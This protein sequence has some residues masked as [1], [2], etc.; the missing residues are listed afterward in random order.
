MLKYLFETVMRM[1]SELIGKFIKELREEKKLTQLMLAE[2]IPVTRE[3]VSKWERGKNNPD[4]ETLKILAN[5]FDVTVE[6]LILGRRNKNHIDESN[7]LTLDLYEQNLKKEKKIKIVYL[8]LFAIL[9]IFSLYYFINTFNTIKVYTIIY[10]DE[11]VK[12]NNGIFVTTKDKI[13]FNLSDIEC[14]SEINSLKLY[15]KENNIDNFIYEIDNNMIVL[16][17]F[18]GYDEYFNYSKLSQIIDNLYLDIN[19]NDN[20]YTAKL[21]LNEDF[22]NDKFFSQ[23]RP[24]VVQD[25]DNIIRYNYSNIDTDLIKSKLDLVDDVY[26]YKKENIFL[27]YF[28]EAYLLN[29]LQDGETK[30]V[31][32]YYV[33]N[34]SL[35]YSEYKDN[36]LIKSF[37]YENEEL[38][39]YTDNCV[40]NNKE[41]NYFFETIKSI[42]Y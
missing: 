23:K 9:A 2:K 41:V 12:I 27:T 7:E 3:A 39:C 37:L 8:I 4:K 1:N 16:Y 24:N 22:K 25:N 28:E 38:Q 34:D 20:V 13:Y 32:N 30:K 6:E 15:Y 10:E 17:D 33:I 36:T 42:L 11:N 14:N 19:C 18:Y 29:L 31:W 21:K 26:I 40:N 35:E 5:I